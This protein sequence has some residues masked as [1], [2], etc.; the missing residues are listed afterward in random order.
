VNTQR[1]NADESVLVDRDVAAL[2]YGHGV[3]GLF[4]TAVAGTAFVVVLPGLHAQPALLA[5]L[6]IMLI[7]VVARALD[8]ISGRKR[9]AK[10]DWNGRAEIR[11]FGRGV[12]A[13]AAVWAI[14]PLLFFRELNGV[15]RTTMAI[16]FSAMAGGS[17]TVL[18]AVRR[19]AIVYC[20]ALLLPSS[21]MF[22]LTPGHE[23][24]V[25]GLLGIVFFAVMGSSTRVTHSATMA[26]IRL[27]RA[28]QTLMAD[29]DSERRHTERANADLTVAQSALR[30]TLESLEDRIRARTAD[31]ER[32]INE[33]ER[34]AAE[35]A[36][37]ASRDSL[38]GFYNRTTLTDR[39]SSE[40]FR[41]ERAG[42]AIAVLF[43]DLDHFKEVND[44][45]GH[46]WGDH[47]LREVADRLSAIV[48][49]D[50][51]CARWGG[52]EFVFVLGNVERAKA[53]EAASAVATQLRRIVCGPISFG[54]ETVRV[55]AT[56][57]IALFP[58]HGRTAD[59]LIRAA[60]MAMYAAKE[61]GRGRIRTFDPA[62]AAE[63]RER[64][65]LEEA[66]REAIPNDELRLEFQPI[67]D[68]ANWRCQ[69]LEALV[70]W[71]HPTRGT[72]GPTEF[73]PIAERSGD[74]IPIGRWVLAQACAA[75]K[76]W[77]G[78]RPPALSLNVSIAQIVGGTVLDDV[79][80]A[81][82]ASGLDAHRLHVE[83][84]ETLFAND[85][86]LIIPTL[87]ALRAMGIRI[88]L[89]DFGTGFS[90]LSYLRSLPID[91]LKIDKSFVN[92]V[93]RDSGP[94]IRAIRSLADAFHIEVIAEGVETPDEAA[95]LLSM[96]VNCLQGYL[97]AA[98]LPKNDVEA[99]LTDA[100]ISGMT[101][102]G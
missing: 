23:N 48:P 96:G 50:A 57:G 29:M 94:I 17:V 88:S 8:L 67:V 92:D 11:R 68:A 20:A 98:P 58:H 82:S 79:R 21:I 30:E 38:T 15:E 12:L 62:L 37:L 102:I 42:T 54:T 2:L 100:G 83:V 22:L 73:I 55:D 16:V 59:E 85:H 70:R 46:Y 74:I 53:G 80:A 77:P 33:R 13:C 90:S 4:V 76:S 34:Y 32:E 26:A 3:G 60:D 6:S 5:W 18:A 36:R 97:F 10:D 84:T 27:N 31:L 49:T 1:R 44:L 91:T 47:V 86:K 66:L 71:E 95:T 61:S 56:I 101:P 75:A 65:L 35:L 25:L 51:I 40:R 78:A 7:T 63:L 72:I 52:D 43:L 69:A 64:R 99:W 14:F 45:K 9:R 81:L 93:Q 39:L 24:G 41:A 87:T 19:L 28:N 89:D